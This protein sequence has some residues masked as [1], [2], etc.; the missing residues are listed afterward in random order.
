MMQKFKKY[1]KKL[2]KILAKPEMSILPGNIAYFFV[3]AL[4]PLLTII[5]LI[6][7]SFSISIDSVTSLVSS[8]FPEEI[9]TTI[10]EV[11][12][13]K[14]FDTNIGI[15]NIIAFV[16]AT[17]G[18]Y[19][20]VTAANSL[21]NVK[22]SDPIKDRIKSAIILIIIVILLLFLILVPILGEQILT[23]LKGI[24]SLEK[25][26]PQIIVFFNLLKWPLSFLII[27]FNVKLIYTIAPSKEV[28]SSETSYGAFFTTVVWVIATA[29]FS[30]Y[31]KYFASYDIIY[32]NLST[33]IILM[34]WLFALSYIFVFGMAINTTK[35]HNKDEIGQ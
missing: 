3:L 21:Y 23:L 30:Y 14:G 32:G 12:S 4:I 17:N 26:I 1:I 33:I 8:I 31:V 22:E 28:K 25:V 11:I 29:I 7:S 5:I 9:A 16:V 15:F 19:A 18:T 35:Y 20:I 6:A 27:Y 13:G 24:E 2:L 34:I 10:I